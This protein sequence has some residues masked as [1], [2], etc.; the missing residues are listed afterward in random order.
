MDAIKLRQHP[1]LEQ[2]LI[3]GHSYKMMT[4][5]NVHQIIASAKQ[6]HFSLLG[7]RAHSIAYHPHSYIPS[8]PLWQGR[9]CPGGTTNPGRVL[10]WLGMIEFCWKDRRFLVNRITTIF[11]ATNSFKSGQ[12]IPYTQV[13]G[14]H[15]SCSWGPQGPQEPYSVE[16]SVLTSPFLGWS[17]LVVFQ[18]KKNVQ[19][20]KA[21]TCQTW[22][23]S[24]LRLSKVS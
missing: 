15:S 18:K 10:Q 5:A 9:T 17:N 1:L 23:S 3:F 19:S 20:S 2:T 24:V 6:C 7:S 13:A 8:H 22:K 11:S 14:Y 16:S 4:I 12:I 21:H